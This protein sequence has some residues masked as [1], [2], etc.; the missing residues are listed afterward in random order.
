MCKYCEEQ[1]I[2]KE[3]FIGVFNSKRRKMKMEIFRETIYFTIIDYQKDTP[4]KRKDY[5][6]NINYCP[7]CGKKL[8][9]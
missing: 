4:N 3:N 9:E 7:M 2:G 8:G 5:V 1:K 6:V